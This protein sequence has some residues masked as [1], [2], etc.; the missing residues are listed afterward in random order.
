MNDKIIKRLITKQRR[1]TQTCRCYKVKVDKSTLSKKTEDYLSTLFIEAKWFYNYCVSCNRIED[2]DNKTTTIPVKVGDKYEYREL[3]VLA[4]QVRHGIVDQF[5]QSIKSLKSMKING[6]KIGKLKFKSF[7]N[8]IPLRQF[9]H[10]YQIKE[11][12]IRIVKSGVWLKVNGL[13]RIPEDVEIAN[14]VLVRKNEDFYFHIT[15]YSDQKKDPPEASIG[16]D[17]GCETQLTFSNGIKVKFQVP[18]SKRLKRLDRKIMKNS[19]KDSKNKEKDRLK[20]RKEY[21]KLTNR[22]KDIRNKIVHAITTNYKY[23]CFQD[24]SI[25][26]WAQCGHGKKIQSTAIGSIIE[27]LK[28]KSSNPIEVD[29]LFPSTKLCPK[30]GIKNKLSLSERVYICPC[31]FSMDRDI[32]AA[33]MIEYEAMKLVPMDHRELTLG[34]SLTSTFYNELSNINGVIVRKFTH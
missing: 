24:E 4:A 10:T 14:A 32:K 7:V 18:I 30:C 33:K 26:G 27:D 13:D 17:F 5:V 3:K 1:K 34:E 19:R 20:R 16:I 28:H 2:I 21:E 22:K 12:R 25:S 11:D 29:R 15:T 31:G 23:V 8:S 9:C 6:I